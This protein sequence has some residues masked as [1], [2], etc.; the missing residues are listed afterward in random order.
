MGNITNHDLWTDQLSDYLDDELPVTARAALEEHL[1][2]CGDC[3]QVLAELRAVMERARSLPDAP[4]ARE[5]WPGIGAA[6]GSSTRRSARLLSIWATRSTQRFSFTLPQLAAASLA[7]MLL[8]GG[9][10]WLAR[11]GGERTDIP[12]V[13]ADTSSRPTALPAAFIDAYYDGAIADL[14][15]TLD[16]GRAKLDAETI[17]VLEENLAAIDRAI[18]QCRRALANDPMNAY[19][20]D[21]L[22]SAKKRKLGLLRRA[23]AMADASNAGT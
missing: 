15:E 22:V 5:L 11:L 12:A 2:A 7:L 17:R 19:L 3:R 8:S 16:A 18:E 20:S 21:H 13:G 6:I 10:V 23:A 1:H 4:P 14:Q 9:M